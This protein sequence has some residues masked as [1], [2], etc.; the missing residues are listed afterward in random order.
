MSELN[1]DLTR[2]KL[3]VL[4]ELVHG[5]LGDGGAGAR[6]PGGLGVSRDLATEFRS[7]S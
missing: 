5:L 6:A 3:L 7:G 1:D 2:H 4:L